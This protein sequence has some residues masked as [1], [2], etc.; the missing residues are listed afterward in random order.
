MRRSGY[1]HRAGYRSV[2]WKRS[3]DFCEKLCVSLFNKE[4][5]NISFKEKKIHITIYEDVVILIFSVD[6]SENVVFFFDE[7]L[8]CLITG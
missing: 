4:C 6:V 5:E 2:I 1:K 8:Y 7:N 3:F